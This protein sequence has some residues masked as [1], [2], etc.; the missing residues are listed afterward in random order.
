MNISYDYV[1]LVFYVKVKLQGKYRYR[2]KGK[3]VEVKRKRSIITYKIIPG[4]P[5]KV[6]R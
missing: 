3:C 6:G 2:H 5:L 1:P 4:F